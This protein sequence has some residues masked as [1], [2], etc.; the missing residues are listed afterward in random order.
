[1]RGFFISHWPFINLK[2]KPKME[3]HGW[4]MK[5]AFS[6]TPCF[7]WVQINA[8]EQKTVSTV[9]RAFMSQP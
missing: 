3:R 7:S 2:F 1:L 5:G 9:F 8:G 6:L 4:L